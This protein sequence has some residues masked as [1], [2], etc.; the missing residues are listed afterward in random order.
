MK[1]PT[2]ALNKEIARRRGAPLEDVPECEVLLGKIVLHRL[3]WEAWREDR[4]FGV[5]TGL[6][7]V[8]SVAIAKAAHKL[9]TITAVEVIASV[10]SLEPGPYRVRAK[11]ST[12]LQRESLQAL[13]VLMDAID[14]AERS[15]DG[16]G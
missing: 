12:Y 4:F 1:D 15:A 6:I 2:K 10:G 5:A 16:H 14:F 7:R 13:L 3:F 8:E 9:G 11:I